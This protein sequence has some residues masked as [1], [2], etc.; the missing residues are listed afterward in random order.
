MKNKN[1]HYANSC[2]HAINLRSSPFEI[3]RIQYSYFQQN[4]FE[5]KSITTAVDRRQLHWNVVTT[6]RRFDTR[7]KSVF[8]LRTVSLVTQHVIT[9]NR[10]LYSRAINCVPNNETNDLRIARITRCNE[11]QKTPTQFV[12]YRTS[13]RN[14]RQV[15]TAKFICYSQI[16]LKP[17]LRVEQYSVILLQLY[18]KKLHKSIQC[19]ISRRIKN[20]KN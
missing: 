15:I 13:S 2:Q 6:A 14:C 12:L 18:R 11:V 10:W 20:S 16:R 8:N 17:L 3:K 4:Q 1:W 5:S 19:C 7:R 9:T